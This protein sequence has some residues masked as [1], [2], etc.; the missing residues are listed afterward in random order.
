MRVDI[1]PPGPASRST[2]LENLIDQLCIIWWTDVESV[3]SAVVR[4]F[5]SR[6]RSPAREL[7]EIAPVPV[8]EPVLTPIW[9]MLWYEPVSPLRVC[10]I[11]WRMLDRRFRKS[12]SLYSVPWVGSLLL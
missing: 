1:V 4:A 5:V 3:V 7:A 2:R 11:C 12:L 6:V 10:V 9:S 8:V